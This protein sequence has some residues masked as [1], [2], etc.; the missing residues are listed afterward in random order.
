[1]TAAPSEQVTPPRRLHRKVPRVR[2]DLADWSPP[3]ELERP[4]ARPEAGHVFWGRLP[5]SPA[6]SPVHLLRWAYQDLPTERLLARSICGQ[7]RTTAAPSRP[8]APDVVPVCHRC[9][10]SLSQL[11][12]AAANLRS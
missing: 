9:R 5:E 8:N 2:I 11:K 1:M 3:S 10:L 6:G 7:S 4:P 12:A